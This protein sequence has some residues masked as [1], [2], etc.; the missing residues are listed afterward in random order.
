VADGDETDRALRDDIRFLGELLGESLVRQEG[1]HLLDL[2]EHVRTESKAALTD[3]VA[4]QRLADTLAGVDIAT[5]TLLVKAFLAYFHLANMAEQVHRADE[6]TQR[7][8]ASSSALER[9]VDDI[10]AARLDRSIVADAFAHLDVRPILTAHPTESSRRS[11]LTHRRRLATLLQQRTDSRS[12]D[13]DRRRAE[14]RLAEVVDLLWQTEEVRRE[15]P[16]PLDEA[17][18]ALFY[19]DELAGSVLPDLLDDLAVHARRVGVDMPTTARPLRLGTWVGGDRD[20]NPSVTPETTLA[21]LALQRDHAVGVLLDAVDALIDGLSISTRA[22]GVSR[23]LLDSLERDRE[24]LPAV[25]ERWGRLDA[26]E[27]YRLKCSYIRE[28]LVGTRR[29]ATTGS[30]HRPGFDYAD[31][32]ELVADLEVLYRSLA[33]NKGELVADG[34]VGRM[35]RTARAVGLQ[36]ATMDVR[37]HSSRH[38]HALAALYERLGLDPPYDELD[39]AARTTLLAGELAGGRPLSLATTSVDAEASTTVAVFTTIRRALDRYGEEAIESYIVSMTKGV[40]DV[41][42]AVVL[43]RDAGLVDL[44]AGVARIG[45]VPLIETIDE[46]CSAGPLLDALLWEPSYRRLVALRGNLQEVMLGYS[47]S[48]KDGGITAS[49]WAIHRA[50]RALR[51]V[52]V[53]H[54]VTLRLFHGRGGTVGR[55]GGPTGRA[56]LAQPF[57]TVNGAIKITEQGEVVSDKYL[58]PELARSNLETTVAAVLQATLMHRESRH[59]RAVLERWD[60]AMSVVSDASLVAYRRFVDHPDLVAYFLAST[61]VEEMGGMNIGSR[62]TRRATEPAGGLAGLRAIPWVFGWT[63]SRQIVPGWY[64][65]GSG[66]R[67]AQAAGLG[68]VLDEMVEQWHFFPTFLANVEMALFK[69]DLDITRLY[70]ERLVDPPLHHVF[71]DIAEE[72]GRTV[73]EIVRLL[74]THSLLDAHPMLR[75]TLSTRAAYLAPMHHLQTDLLQRR[76]SAAHSDPQ[77][78]RALLL[79]VNGIASGLRNTG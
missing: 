39:H 75:R 64:G 14:R 40:D 43:A 54:G 13:A 78:E 57:R 36:L 34:I 26:D 10:V 37:E 62:P 49:S 17:R 28:R 32:D 41:L 7:T 68:P 51:D 33:S 59:E 70:V 23:E 4:R 24:V 52:A 65:V 38:H 48:N 1:A 6:L 19:L 3:P 73:D 18:A 2:V 76:R 16:T 45:F 63:Q 58:L 60:E 35:L 29:R 79:T 56:I 5:G 30:I 50:Q 15:R 42:A 69:T 21:V 12:S 27:P 22:V 20:G 53:S 61:P 71:D 66:L 72:H 74:R 31:A 67:A 46:L 11:I 77:L 9:T 8:L 25:L 55:G 44:R 47:D